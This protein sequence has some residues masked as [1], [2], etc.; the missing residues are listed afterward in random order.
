MR[1]VH[2]GPASDA[3]VL[4]RFGGAVQRRIWELARRQRRRGHR[5][6]IYTFDRAT[7][8]RTVEGVEIR[9]LRCL[10]PHPARQLELLA[11]ALLDLRRRE[12]RVDVLHFHG[13][14][15]GA[16]L[17]R[18][19]AGVTALSFDFF[20]WRRGRRTPWGPLYRSLLGRFDLLLPCSDWCRDGA[21]RYWDLDPAGLDVLWNGV[22]LDQFAPDPVACERE[23]QA[24]GVVGPVLLYVGRVCEQKGSHVLLEGYRRLRARG[25]EAA[26]VVA[27]PIGQFGSGET[28]NR[29]DWPGRIA[30]A[31]GRYLGPVEEGR[32]AAVYNLATALVMPTTY[33]E[34][35]GMAAVEAQACGVPVVASDHGGL[36]ETVPDGAGLRFETGSAEALADRL[37]QLLASPGLRATLAAGARRNVARFGW[38]RICDR[39]DAL[40]ASRLDP[41]VAPGAAPGTPGPGLA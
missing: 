2:L 41:K 16:A 30:A 40:V 9:S 8:A 25:V 26:L 31:G 39:L 11:R 17:A 14:P 27:G 20:G 33:N 7:G 21:A 19:L 38:E 22:D 32:L 4:H 1:I 10:T 37:A 35:F 5:V 34:M 18:G 23:R 24:L 15:E 13:V 29:G 36:R 12:G 28:V 6:A 3:P